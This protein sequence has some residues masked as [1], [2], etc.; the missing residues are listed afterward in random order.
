MQEPRDSFP[1]DWSPPPTEFLNQKVLQAPPESHRRLHEMLEQEP[2]DSD[3]NVR[4]ASLEDLFW[5]MAGPSQQTVTPELAS[6]DSECYI[7]NLDYL[8]QEKR[9]QALEQEWEQLLLQDH[10]NLDSSD[11]YEDDSEVQLTPEHRM[12]VEKFS[13]SLQVIPSVHPG[14]TVFLPR[15]NP[16]PLILDCS[17]LKPHSPLEELFFRSSLPQQLSF[18]HKGL[19]SN[20]YLHAPECPLPLLRWLFQLLTWP[21]ETSLRAF[22]LLWDLSIDGLFRQSNEGMHLWCPSLQE[23]KEVFHSLGA[24]N[25]APYPQGSFQHRVLES[26]TSLGWWEQQDPPQEMALDITLSYIYRFL[27]LCFIVHPRSYTD[28]S[29]LGLIELLCRTGLDVG[30]CLL[31]KMDLQQLLLVLLENI[32]EWPGKLQPLCCALS[33]VSDHHHNLLALVQF[34]LDVTSRARQLRS[35]LSLMVIAQMLG[36]QEV[37]PL[38]GKKTQLSLLS[39]L[40]SL[41]RPSSLRQYLSAEPLPLCQGQQPKTSTKLDHKVCYLCHSLLTLAGVVVSSQEITLDQWGELQ[42]L[43]MQ[44]DRHISTH[45][46]ESPQAMHWTKLKDLATQTYIRWQDLLAHCQPQSQYFSPWKDI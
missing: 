2:L 39:Q 18:L 38:W 20:L 44:L 37:L 36:Q 35:Q 23:V 16:L 14:E 11:C 4:L 15:R 6:R 27:T 29:L 31:P 22:N 19:L 30:L 46:R 28:T 7:N 3:Q 17:Q 34:F 40:L 24:Y 5:N 41:M 45:I 1:T 21:P 32:Q 8:L 43:C 10:L 33:W 12:L 42:L 9:E 26:K 13:V 25:P